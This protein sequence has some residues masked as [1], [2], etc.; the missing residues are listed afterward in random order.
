MYIEQLEALNEKLKDDANVNKVPKTSDKHRQEITEKNKTISSLENVVKKLEA[1]VDSLQAK[2]DKLDDDFMTLQVEADLAADQEESKALKSK[3]DQLDNEQVRAKSQIQQLKSQLSRANDEKQNL[4]KL[5]EQNTKRAEMNKNNNFDKANY[6]KSRQELAHVKELLEKSQANNT[7]SQEKLD[8]L[9]KAHRNLQSENSK[10]KIDRD[11][12][13]QHV[14]DLARSKPNDPST[15]AFPRRETTDINSDFVTKF[16]NMK[17]DYNMFKNENRFLKERVRKLTLKISKNQDL[18]DLLKSSSSDEEIFDKSDSHSEISKPKRHYSV[19]SNEPDN[20]LPHTV[21]PIPVSS[22][23]PPKLAASSITVARTRNVAHDKQTSQETSTLPRKD[24]A[25][26]PV[27]PTL[28]TKQPSQTRQ[29]S[30][31]SPTSPVQKPSTRR[32]SAPKLFIPQPKQAAV[33]KNKKKD[34]RLTKFVNSRNPSKVIDSRPIISPLHDRPSTTE[35]RTAK[36]TKL[37]MRYASMIEDWINQKKLATLADVDVDN[38]IN[39]IGINY[40]VMKSLNNPDP[41]GVIK[42]GIEGVYQLDVPDK[43][44]AREKG[45]AWI[46]CFHSSKNVSKKHTRFI[47]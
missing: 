14:D 2:Y 45:Y 15:A 10:L 25:T 12:L 26:S 47:N 37:D 42:F 6:D 31:L 8:I 30:D 33:P 29:T 4:K 46:L 28:T 7:M 18:D 21:E 23:Q 43:W 36:R 22:G 39:E 40:K 3:L 32:V 38:I 34:N 1:E 44:D 5:L 11:E 27:R 19:T 13:R 17:T 35:E 41:K 16:R 9:Q 20:V 24:L